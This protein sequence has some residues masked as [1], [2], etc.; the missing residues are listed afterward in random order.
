VTVEEATADK[1]RILPLLSEFSEV[2]LANGK[3]QGPGYGNKLSTTQPGSECTHKLL[4]QKVWEAKDAIP[5]KTHVE[6]ASQKLSLWEM[7]SG[8]EYYG[9]V[10]D[11]FRIRTIEEARRSAV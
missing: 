3:L 5:Q 8:F 9:G 11:E 7:K 1:A 2:A 6:S 10:Q 4:I